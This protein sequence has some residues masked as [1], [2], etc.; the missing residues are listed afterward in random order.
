M[1]EEFIQSFGRIRIDGD[2]LDWC[3]RFRQIRQSNWIR[4]LVSFPSFVRG[5]D[6]TDVQTLFINSVPLCFCYREFILLYT[7]PLLLL[8]L[9][10][11][12]YSRHAALQGMCCDASTEDC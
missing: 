11:V 8:I 10:L 2:R 6:E 7:R 12:L 1:G 9:Q 4:R 5:F 3:E